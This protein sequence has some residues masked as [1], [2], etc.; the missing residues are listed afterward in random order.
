MTSLVLLFPRHIEHPGGPLPTRALIAAAI[1]GVSSAALIIL[2]VVRF[3]VQRLRVATMA[4]MVVLLLFVVGVGPFFGFGRVAKT[5]NTAM[6]LNEVYSARPMARQ[7]E[8]IAPPGE[9]IAVYKVRRDMEYGLSF[10]RNHQVFNYEGDD[11]APPQGGGPTAQ[12]PA[13]PRPITVPE[14][15][16]ILVTRES[17]THELPQVLQGR[18]YE[19]LFSYPAQNLVVYIVSARP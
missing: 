8:A 13:A 11:E 3:G 17:Y 9:M 4:P 19:E 7:L 12:V 6:L 2:C 16:H 1:V 18:N 15:Q 10:Y 14:Q 5:K